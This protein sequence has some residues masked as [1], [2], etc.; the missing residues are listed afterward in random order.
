MPARSRIGGQGVT[1]MPADRLKTAKIVTMKQADLSDECWMVQMFGLS[2]CR[3]CEFKNTRDC[4]GK[5]IRKTGKTKTGKI[6]PDK[7]I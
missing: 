3:D 7:T 6:V 4:G 1:H 2:H 5:N